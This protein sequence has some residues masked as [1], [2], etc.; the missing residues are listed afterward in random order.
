VAP[1]RRRRRPRVTL[2]FLVLLSITVITL[3]F[4]GDSGGLVK[5]ARGVAS[6][7][8]SPVRDAAD[9][10]LAP[11]GDAFSG[12]T[13][14]GSLKDENERLKQRI[15]DL[16][17]AQSTD[18][19]AR[20]DLD[21]LLKLNGLNNELANYKRVAARV[22]AAPVS[23]FEQTIELNVGSDKGVGVDMP[24]VTGAGLVGRV[25]QVFGKRAVVRLITDPASS[26]GVRLVIS[27][28]AGIAEG[29]GPRREL[30]VSYVSIDTKVA[31]DELL[32]TSGLA[33][34]SDLYP[35]NIP[36]GK[37]RSAEQLEGALDERVRIS[38]VADLRN[39]VYV[40]VVITR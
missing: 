7:A 27:G 3:D 19:A 38:P 37:V 23:N 20:A 32:V 31:T 22:V 25:V 1:S 17:G 36:V 16:E 13:G 21:Q 18:S 14:Y 33:G 10:V 34:G 8:F 15:A 35:P 9:S 6:D 5:T 30:S 24:V 29:E 26:V 28:E 11:V 40:S 2:V 4:R 12:V 39:L